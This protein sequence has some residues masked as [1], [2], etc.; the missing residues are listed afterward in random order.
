MMPIIT[1]RKLVTSVPSV[2]DALFRPLLIH[3]FVVVSIE[4]VVLMARLL[5]FLINFL[6]NSTTEQQFHSLPCKGCI[7]VRSTILRC[8][9]FVP[10]L[11][12]PYEDKNWLTNY[13]AK[14]FPTLI[15]P[16]IWQ[17]CVKEMAWSTL[18]TKILVTNQT[19]TK[20]IWLPIICLGLCW[21]PTK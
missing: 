16:V 21:L 18:A 4:S 20:Q 6:V 19:S 15:L 1:D 11:A 5:M 10:H 13:L 7:L 12:L 3:I 9:C 2:T 14:D 17:K 8:V